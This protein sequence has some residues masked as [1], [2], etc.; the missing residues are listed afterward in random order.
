MALYW[1]YTS[2]NGTE[3]VLLNGD[4]IAAVVPGAHPRFRE[5]MIFLERAKARGTDPD[6]EQVRELLD[7]GGTLAA[8]VRRLSERVTWDGSHLRFDGDVIDTS[9]SRHI[10]RMIEAGDEQYARWVRFWRTWP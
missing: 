3:S 10:I 2:D 6:P 4:G 9:L 1:K 5:I 8:R 7:I